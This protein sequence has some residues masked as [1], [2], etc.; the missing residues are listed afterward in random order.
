MLSLEAEMRQ[1]LLELALCANGRTTNLEGRVAGGG[2]H[3]SVI[4]RQVEEPIQE[5]LLRRW[6]RCRSDRAR[7]A[8]LEDAREALRAIR[9]RAR[10]PRD[11][12]P[13]QEMVAADPRPTREVA[14]DWGITPR[15]VQ[16]LR[17]KFRHSSS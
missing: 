11:S 17:A 9:H 5:R 7:R 6:M 8:V 13:W 16:Q 14:E 10:P 1:V 3:R 12:R 15:Y 2:G 4:L